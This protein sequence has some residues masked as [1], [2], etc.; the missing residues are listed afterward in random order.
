MLLHAA[1]LCLS[2][3]KEIAAKEPRPFTITLDEAAVGP[4]SNHNEVGQVDSAQFNHPNASEHGNEEAGETVTFTGEDQSENALRVDSEVEA[5]GKLESRVF[6]VEELR[7]PGERDN[8]DDPTEN[9]KE[10]RLR[11]VSIEAGRDAARTAAAT[12]T[13]P[14]TTT[15]PK[16]VLVPIANGSCES[17]TMSI[18]TCLS[19]CGIQVTLASI[20]GD[21]DCHVRMIFST[22]CI[23]IT[24]A[25]AYR[26][27][28]YLQSPPNYL[29]S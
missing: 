17:Q 6:D 16:R 11:G 7:P 22:V 26:E 4:G 21:D 14:T 20:N 27:T 3:I 24:L 15:A 25:I 18:V 12:T 29:L 5:K 9:E 8:E 13:T 1:C 28:G 10:S 19:K 2:L 23:I